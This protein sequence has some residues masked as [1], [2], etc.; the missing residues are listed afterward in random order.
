LVK[1]PA[2]Q[3]VSESDG[4]N[5]AAAV[6]AAS[7]AH[8]PRCSLTLLLKVCETRGEKSSEVCARQHQLADTHSRRAIC[9]ITFSLL[10]IYLASALCVRGGNTLLIAAGTYVIFGPWREQPSRAGPE[11]QV[12]SKYANIADFHYNEWFCGYLLEKD[13]RWKQYKARLENQRGFHTQLS[14]MFTAKN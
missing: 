5:L 13:N 4:K 9:L 7:N 8:A 6:A 11:L 12:A 1:T 10:R 3:T 2:G 14:T